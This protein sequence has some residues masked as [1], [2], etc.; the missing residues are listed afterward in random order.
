MK[1]GVS[2]FGHMLDELAG[3]GLCNVSLSVVKLEIASPLSSGTFVSNWPLARSDWTGVQEAA[4]L[5]IGRLS[6]SVCL[7]MNDFGPN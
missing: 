1:M 3:T 6:P 7:R 4:H 5:D 2:S